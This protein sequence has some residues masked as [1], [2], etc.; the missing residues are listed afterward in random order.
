MIFFLVLCY[1]MDEKKGD[2]LYILVNEWFTETLIQ[3]E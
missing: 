3:N 2:L 1:L